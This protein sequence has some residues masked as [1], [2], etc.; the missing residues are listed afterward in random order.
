ML[1]RLLGFLSK[2]KPSDEPD[3]PEQIS[4]DEIDD[5]ELRAVLTESA[6]RKAAGLD[7]AT[8]I[9]H[10]A[11]EHSSFHDASPQPNQKLIVV[12]VTFKNHQGGFGLAGVE[13]LEAQ[14]GQVESLGG[15]PHKIFLQEDGTLMKDQSGSY[16]DGPDD[17]TGPIRVFLVYSVRKTVRKIAL[18][19]WTKVLVERA[20]DVGT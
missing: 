5:P 12:D 7:E 14:N 10:S 16:L 15:D 2:T 11:K 19:Y 3:S 9:I 18:G 8:V 13:L 20:Y 6:R 4:L 1:K 17:Y